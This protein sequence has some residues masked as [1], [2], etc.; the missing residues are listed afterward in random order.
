MAGVRNQTSFAFDAGS[1]PLQKREVLTE[2]KYR[3]YRE[4]YGT[5]FKAGDRTCAIDLL[6]KI[7][8]VLLRRRTPAA[9]QNTV[10]AET[11]AAESRFRIPAADG[12]LVEFDS[13]TEVDGET[14]TTTMRPRR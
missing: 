14:F 3:E 9:V 1:T 10:R 8:L 6:R 5:A 13:W 2:Q 11:G 7:A 4:K 12:S